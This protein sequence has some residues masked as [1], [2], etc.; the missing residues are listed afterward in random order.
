M[1]AASTDRRELRIALGVGLTNACNLACAHCYRSPGSDSLSMHDVLRAVS[2]LPVRAVNF[3]TGENGLHPELAPLARE[4]AAQGIA[5]TMTTNGYSAAALPDDVLALFADVELSIDFPSQ[6]E[7]DRA[8]G[9]GNWALIEEQMARCA[10]LGVRT[11]IASVLMAANHRALPDLARLAGSRGALLRVNVFQ[12]VRGD[13]FALGYDAFWEAWRAL[14]DMADVVS[15]GE[16]IVRAMLGIPRAPGAGCGVETVR[17]TPRG[18]VV[19][20]VYGADDELRVDDVERLGAAVVD[21]PSFRRLNVVPNECAGCPH[22]ATCGGGCPSRRALR[23]SLDRGDEYCPI[24]RGRPL[25]LTARA[26]P[27]GR[28]SAKASSACTVIV[29]ARSSGAEGARVQARLTGR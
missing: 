5:V 9:D 19:P 27:E 29:A 6:A 18:A 17:I 2:A 15:C 7:H 25:P 20:C 21:E 14:F 24:L 3:G 22:V 11:T 28:V 8:R 26:A 23:G 16:P 13:A 4:L 12:S 10:R 1:S